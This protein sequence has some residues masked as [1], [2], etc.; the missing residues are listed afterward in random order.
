VAPR[1]GF[2]R[3]FPLEPFAECD[4][5]IALARNRI[6]ATEIDSAMD[7]EGENVIAAWT[8]GMNRSVKTY[9]VGLIDGYFPPETAVLKVPDISHIVARTKSGL[10]IG[11]MRSDPDTGTVTPVL[12]D[13]AA[14]TYFYFKEPL[15]A[16]PPFTRLIEVPLVETVPVTIQVIAIREPS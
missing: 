13:L 15:F 4:G 2:I 8:S 11:D 16:V 9:F 6:S 7:L 12:F 1:E 14:G 5:R 3:A 10:L